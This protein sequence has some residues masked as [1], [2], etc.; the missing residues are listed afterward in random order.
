MSG[1]YVLDTGLSWPATANYRY[2]LVRVGIRTPTAHGDRPL[3]IR[4]ASC[5]IPTSDT[6]SGYALQMIGFRC[7]NEN[8]ESETNQQ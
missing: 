4:V 6:S 8:T 7:A 5:E 2:R 1:C 3:V